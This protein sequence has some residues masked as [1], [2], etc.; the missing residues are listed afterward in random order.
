MMLTTLEP[1]TTR[2]EA[3]V[4]AA[5]VCRSIRE[6]REYGH[7]ALVA[8]GATPA[9]AAA[10]ADT[11][12]HAELHGGDG[13][14]QLAAALHDGAWRVARLGCIR[15][16]QGATTVLDVTVAGSPGLLEVGLPV[17]G[18]VA[19]EIGPAVARTPLSGGEVSSL[20]DAPLLDAA[21]LRGDTVA[22][23][24]VVD[25]GRAVV[26]AATP[27]GDVL[28]GELDRSS[29]SGAGL[30]VTAGLP[31]VG[32]VVTVS[33][34][35]DRRRQRAGLARHGVEVDAAAWGVVAARAHDFL[36]PDP[37]G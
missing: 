24:T 28:V 27:D 30:T 18:L 23:A 34:D 31:V 2:R 9:E 10:V 19:G 15:L 32:R 7:R 16:V 4:P 17:I 8:S 14:V 11:V 3:L 36:V 37:P 13:M 29:V 21:R 12:L 20:L 5:V 25:H 26:R 1:T 33:R 6:V 35:A 22:A